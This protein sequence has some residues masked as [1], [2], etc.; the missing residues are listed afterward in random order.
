VAPAAGR[1]TSPQL[2]TPLPSIRSARRRGIEGFVG[3]G[4]RLIEQLVG[5]VMVSSSLLLLKVVLGL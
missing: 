1:R 3:F 5:L 2:R 4:L